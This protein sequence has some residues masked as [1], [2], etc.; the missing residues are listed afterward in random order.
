[1]R[2]GKEKKKVVITGRIMLKIIAV[3]TIVAV[4]VS[5]II[6]VVR[7]TPFLEIFTDR[8][9]MW[10]GGVVV[11]FFILGDEKKE[12]NKSEKKDEE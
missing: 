10:I 12:K 2:T 1:M 3:I 11:I 4:I 8:P 5:A 7:G 6:E 9:L